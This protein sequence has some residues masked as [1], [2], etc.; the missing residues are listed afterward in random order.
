[1]KI[2]VLLADDHIMMRGGL[3]MVLEQNTELS[4]VGEAENGRET[5]R[6]AK[7]LEPD[8]IIMDIAMSDMN[9]IEATR[10]IR[11]DHPNIKVIALSMHSDRHF[12]S[13]MLKA[14]AAAYLV[15][16]C[17]LE[18]LIVAI[19]AV[20][21]GQ[22]YL[23]PCISGVVVEYFVRDKSKTEATAFSKL[24]DREREVLQLMAEGKTSKEIASQL[25]LSVKTIESHRMN[26][27]EKLNIR[28]VAELTKYAIREGITSL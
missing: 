16:Q 20:M 17:A 3:R 25:N 6:L 19:K 13:E 26:I 7:K 10:R 22:T 1:M 12:V 9:G 27:M 15:K 14:G 8:V 23:S 18:E 28:T 24:T 5:V 2:K 11:A 4:V 21:Q